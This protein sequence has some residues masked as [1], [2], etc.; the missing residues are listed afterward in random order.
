LGLAAACGNNGEILGMGSK[1]DLR[2]VPVDRGMVRL[3]AGNGGFTEIRGRQER[4][5]KAPEEGFRVRRGR[6][7]NKYTIV[8]ARSKHEDTGRDSKRSVADIHE[9]MINP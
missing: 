6:K 3:E 8:I 9:D 7:G 5:I 2:G 4:G 1:N